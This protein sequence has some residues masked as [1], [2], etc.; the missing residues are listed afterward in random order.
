M[1]FCLSCSC[2]ALL[3]GRRSAA[4][5]ICA[6]AAALAAVHASVLSYIRNHCRPVHFFF[7]QTKSVSSI[8]MLGLVLWTAV[9]NLE[10]CVQL[11]GVTVTCHFMD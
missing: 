7:R 10:L 5:A 11:C 1:R 6:F 4:Y 2:T 9:V 3:L 8:I